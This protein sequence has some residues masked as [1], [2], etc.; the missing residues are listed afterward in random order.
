MRRRSRIVYGLAFLVLLGGCAADSDP[1]FPPLQTTTQSIAAANVGPADGPRMV[2]YELTG[3]AVTFDGSYAEPMGGAE[4]MVE[5]R[6][7]A[8]PWGRNF[9]IQPGQLFVAGLVAQAP[10]LESTIT[11]R[12]I[13]NGAILAE[14]TGP[15]VDCRAEV[16]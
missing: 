14:Q 11:C 10:N 7:I 12:I 6:G 1:E 15:T 2:R 3:T 8:L 16:S 5:L 9:T 13:K 4:R